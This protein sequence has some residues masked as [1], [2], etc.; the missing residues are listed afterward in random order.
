MYRMVL[1]ASSSESGGLQ[2]FI[3]GKP[4]ETKL[5]YQ[6]RSVEMKLNNET[7]KPIIN[8]VNDGLKISYSA[9]EW[10]PGLLVIQ[11]EN[12]NSVVAVNQ[13][14]MESNF[15]TLTNKELDKLVKSDLISTKVIDV[16]RM[17]SQ[18]INQEIRSAGFGTEIWNWFIWAG[19]F[20]L[21]L[22][23]VVAKSYRTE[24]V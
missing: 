23:T 9:E 18:E 17:S 10:S 5:P 24:T 19:L 13:N 4:F 14:I 16:G 8:T 2:N 22:E 20:C 15:A 7:V 21:I 12:K 1:F 3:L 6:V 11:E